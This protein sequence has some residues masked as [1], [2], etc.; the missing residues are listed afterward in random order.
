MCRL[1]FALLFRLNTLH[2]SHLQEQCAGN[3]VFRVEGRGGKLFS[4][5]IRVCSCKGKR[6]NFNT[7]GHIH[8][9]RQLSTPNSTLH[10]KS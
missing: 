10:F 1:H 2:I 7:S 3:K 4:S 9:S 8:P 6:Y 5:A